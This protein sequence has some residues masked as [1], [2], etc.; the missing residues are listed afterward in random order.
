MNR[1]FAIALAATLLAAG[2]A[3]DPSDREDRR[4]TATTLEVDG[5]SVG[6]DVLVAVPAESAMERFEIQDRN[7][8][9]VSYV[10]FTDTDVGGL[11]FIDNKL[12]G[13]VSKRDARAF[14]SC[15]GYV[16]ATREH[17][18]QDAG[19]WVDS[20]IASVAPASRATLNFSGKTT[21]RSIKEVVANPVLSDVKSLV[22]MGT[23]PLGVINTSPPD[24]D[25]RWNSP[26]DSQRL[27]PSH[28]MPD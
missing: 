15:R 6:R 28:G 20:L 22:G 1:T 11:L 12:L 5:G 13:T 27:T 3:T 26:S 10:A 16:S 14:Y 24:F 19:E 4:L 2:C 23:N 8:H 21:M 25:S 17:W 7:G 18:A 9:R